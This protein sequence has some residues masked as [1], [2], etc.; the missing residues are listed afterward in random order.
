[1]SAA[2]RVLYVGRNR[3]FAR[4]IH[5]V[6]LD[7]VGIYAPELHQ[8]I[9]FLHLTSQKQTLQAIQSAPCS[10]LFLELDRRKNSRKRF[11]LTLRARIPELCIIAVGQERFREQAEAAFDEFLPIPLNIEQASP[12]LQRLLRGGDG[13]QSAVGALRLD[14]STRTVDGPAG[15]RNLS[16]K[17]FDL[18]SL[19]MENAGRTVSREEIIKAVWHTEYV[20]DTRTLDVHIH[21]LRACIEPDQSGNRYLETVRGEGYRLNV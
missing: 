6:L 3:A 7:Q 19:L 14:R 18:L 4:Q 10:G 20:G 12:V 16:P 17:L 2:V 13:A 1:M 21:W 5:D 15:R 8:A 11:C 9:T